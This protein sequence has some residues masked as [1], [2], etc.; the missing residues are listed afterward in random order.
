MNFPL[1][2]VFTV[3]YGFWIVVFSFS[4]VPRYLLISSL[5]SLTYLLF[6]NMLFSFQV[7]ICLSVFLWLISSFIALW[8]ENMLDMISVFWNL[9]WLV[10]CPNMCSIL[11]NVLWALEKF[12]YSAALRWNALKVSIK[13]IWSRVWIRLLS[14]C[15]FSVW[16]IYPL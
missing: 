10:L 2:N 3:S 8:W 16:K 9:L 5:V 11:E 4:F 14:P 1:K 15:W 12:V 13:S 7:F 6:N